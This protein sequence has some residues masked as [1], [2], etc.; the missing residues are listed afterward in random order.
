MSLRSLGPQA[1]YMRPAGVGECHLGV[2]RADVRPHGAGFVRIRAGAF[3]TNFVTKAALGLSA[4]VQRHTLPGGDFDRT[5]GQA[6]L[7]DRH[8]VEGAGR[9]KRW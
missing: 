5:Q 4:A 6:A 8:A 1:T 9:T 7:R 3:V 2:P